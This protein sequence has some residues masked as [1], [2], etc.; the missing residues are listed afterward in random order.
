MSQVD[1]LPAKHRGSLDQAMS[2]LNDT[3][4]RRVLRALKEESPRQQDTFE[5]GEFAP[6]DPDSET[7]QIDLHHRHLPKLD[8]TGYI[9]WK[10]D[11]GQIRRGAD[12]DEIRPLLKLLDDHPVK[13][14]A[15]CP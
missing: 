2:A 13:L 3:T 12:F 14:P 15:K 1:G 11:T 8:E 9:D 6:D 7:I 4:R 10:E 5:T